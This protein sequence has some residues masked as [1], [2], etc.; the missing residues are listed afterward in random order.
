MMFSA[1][2]LVSIVIVMASLSIAHGAAETK[3]CDNNQCQAVNPPEKEPL[4]LDVFQIY[5]DPFSLASW[6]ISDPFRDEFFSTRK[7]ALG[8]AGDLTKQFSPL[9]TSD[10]VE[11]DKDFKVLAD[12]PG[13]SIEDLDVSIEGNVLVMKAE[14]KH[15]HKTDTDKYHTLERSYG[16]VQ[17]R[18]RLPK[19]ADMANANTKFKDGVLT[20]TFPKLA[21]LP[22]SSTKLKINSE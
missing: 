11:T 4:G 5:R 6:Q 3:P 18:I 21:E 22:P 2:V 9:L 19:T 1:N 8:G 16:T 7:F 13:V 15:T 14:R 17:R 10:L 20:V 12:L